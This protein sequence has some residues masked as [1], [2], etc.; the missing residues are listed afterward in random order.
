M[1]TETFEP[2][3][4]FTVMGTGPYVIPHEYSSDAEII[5]RITAAAGVTELILDAEFSV[6]PTADATAGS[7]TLTAIVAAAYEGDKL[8][9][10]RDTI[11]EQGWAAQGGE[12]EGGL[13]KQLDR[14][15]RVAQDQGRRIDDVE[16]RIARSLRVPDGDVAIDAWPDAGMRANRLMSFD[17]TGAPALYDGGLTLNVMQG[18]VPYFEHAIAAGL[19]TVAPE[20]KAIVLLG[21]LAPGDGGGGVFVRRDSEPSHLA[22]I[23]TADGQ[24]WETIED[25][26]TPLAFGARWDGATDDTDAINAWAAYLRTSRKAGRLPPATAYCADTLY[27]GGVR[28]RGAGGPTL[29]NAFASRTVIRSNGNPMVSMAESATDEATYFLTHWEHFT[30][31]SAGGAFQP[32]ELW[33][34]M[35]YPY[36]VG[37]WLGRNHKLM[38]TIAAGENGGGGSGGLTMRNVAVQDASGVGIYAYQLWGKSVIDDVFIRRCGGPA[39]WELG[40]HRGGGAIRIASQCVDTLF[41]AIHS[42]NGGYAD[43]NHNG[44]GFGVHAGGIKEDLEALD[45]LW[46]WSSNIIFSRLH[47][48]RAEAPLIVD[49]TGHLEIRGGAISGHSTDKGAV[50]IGRGTTPVNDVRGSIG[51]LKCFDLSR[52]Y[53]THPGFE[54]GG[55]V[56]R[57]TTVL[58]IHT[59]AGVSWKAIGA[60]SW[61]ADRNGQVTPLIARGNETEIPGG[62][63]D[64]ERHLIL[65]YFATR[66]APA[67]PNSNLLPPFRA[68]GAGALE[69]WSAGVSGTAAAYAP[70]A[71]TTKDGGEIYLNVTDD[72][73]QFL[74]GDLLTFEIWAELVGTNIWQSVEFGI[75]DLAGAEVLRKPVDFGSG[76]SGEIQHRIIQVNVPETVD[77]GGLYGVRPFFTSSTANVVRWRHPF[78]VI[79]GMASSGRAKLTTWPTATGVVAC[80]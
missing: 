79:G 78:L 74:P 40:D 58:E 71:G 49:A 69:D 15:T 44:R 25:E 45:R 17:E 73:L 5:V 77:G 24:W 10:Y 59:W 4:E 6:S 29:A 33:D 16:A 68:S 50:Y 56:N 3:D 2:A 14:Q 62:V 57:G 20:L 8:R 37:I 34:R 36:R 32:I 51:A 9:I 60:D 18:G 55:L 80:I 35:S 47:I 70:W 63:G 72:G 38:E 65:P 75:K 43:A 19:A 21:Q 11:S 31:V 13:E 27:L 30:V 7:V 23:Q 41:G 12:R 42:Y 66:Y 28:I 26:P 22:K 46:A 48:E 64:R 53:V 52:V 54:L 61:G 39:A 76:A 1:T 67:V